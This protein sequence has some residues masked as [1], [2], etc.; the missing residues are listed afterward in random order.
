M[1]KNPSNLYFHNVTSMGVSYSWENTAGSN[2]GLVCSDLNHGD[3]SFVKRS[4][5][6]SLNVANLDLNNAGGSTI[7]KMA[8]NQD[9]YVSTEAVRIYAN[10]LYAGKGKLTDYSIN[11]GSL[12]NESVTNLTYSVGNED[13]SFDEKDDPVQRDESITVSRDLNSKSYTIEHSYSISFGQ[14]NDLISNNPLYKDNPNYSSVDARLALG[15]KEANL[16]VYVN[17]INYG[18]YIDLSAYST[19]A[20]W[21]LEKLEDGCSGVSSSSSSTKNFINGD[22]SLSKTTTLQYTG[23]DLK[24]TPDLYEVSYTMSWGEEQRGKT[25][26]LCA[27]VNMQG[28]IIG[29]GKNCSEELNASVYAESGYDV[30]INQ[31]QAK[32]K[33]SDF[34]DYIKN[35]ISGVPTGAINDAMFNLKKQQC[36]P[37][38]DRGQNKNNGEINFSF[39]MNNCPNYDSEYSATINTSRSS[40]VSYS[41]CGNKRVSV[42][43]ESASISVQAGDCFLPID[44]S[45]NYPKYNSITGAIDKNKYKLLSSGS[46]AGGFSSRLGIKNEQFT[47]NPYQGSESYSVVYSDA[48]EDQNCE[49]IAT[50]CGE[51]KT[52]SKTTPKRPIYENTEGGECGE[53]S[54]ASYSP[55]TKSVSTSLN[56]PKSCPA[57]DIHTLIG[58]VLTELNQNAPSC[59]ITSMSW[60]ASKNADGSMSVSANMEG[61]E[62]T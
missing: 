50:E 33:V 15:E 46:Y 48:S 24:D 12:S 3:N 32:Q 38:V 22:Y 55:S 40:N 60:S 5:T 2:N 47:Y 39:E 19:Q 58:S 62:G 18:Q 21:D 25:N 54:I 59:A 37:S 10:G 8:R 11:E 43:E 42:T 26:E 16:A 41:N 29:A 27:I 36:N 52:K 49:P 23:E 28:T 1:A 45:G 61:I 14:D 51:F 53:Q 9:R 6:V 56:Y 17:P 13:E 20:G 31:G 34:L 35:N 44:L 57:T 7:A 30:F 4:K